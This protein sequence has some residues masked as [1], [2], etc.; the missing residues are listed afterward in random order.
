MSRRHIRSGF[1]LVELL[2]VIGIIG[3]LIALLLPAVQMAREAA[4]SASC[5]NNLKQLGV[6]LQNYHDVHGTFPPGAIWGPRRHSW[7]PFMLPQIEQEALYNQYRWN[8]HWSHPSNQAVVR[9]HLQVLHCP[10]TPGGKDRMV[11]IA[12][13]ITASTTD[14]APPLWVCSRLVQVGQIPQMS[15]RRGV[16]TDFRG[17]RMSEIL[18]GTSNTLTITEDA[19]RPEFWVSGGRG[20]ANNTPGGGGPG[21]PANFPVRNGRVLGAGWADPNNGIPLHGFRSD[22]LRSPGSCAINCTNNN[23]AFSFHPAGINAVFADGG[24][25]FISEDADIRV[26]AAL[27]TRAGGEVVSTNQF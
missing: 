19:G 1:T 5:R 8:I 23:E 2:V 12:N 10:S 3:I 18:D 9:S 27:I 13:G 11:T 22:G 25:R 14:Y 16:M 17:A 6:A 4:R 15:D 26:Y 21:C 24:V 7:V 20:P